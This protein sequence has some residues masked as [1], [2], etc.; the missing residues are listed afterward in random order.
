M[1]NNTEKNNDENLVKRLISDATMKEDGS[2]KVIDQMNGI[3]WM[4][5]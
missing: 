3:D 4:K 5:V 2:I 1:V